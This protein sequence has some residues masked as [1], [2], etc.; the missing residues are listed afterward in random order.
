[1]VD[2]HE[3]ALAKLAVAA[4]TTYGAYKFVS[5]VAAA[6]AAVQ[7][8]VEQALELAEV[9]M[10]RAEAGFVAG[11]GLEIAAGA[12]EMALGGIELGG[13]GIAAAAAL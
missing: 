8:R 9:G 6:R 11:E 3:K 10:A 13:M 5:Y 1:M 12:G 4:G 2:V 7:A